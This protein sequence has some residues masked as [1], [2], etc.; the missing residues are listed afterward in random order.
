M[1]LTVVGSSDAVNAGARGN[2]CYLLESPGA[3]KL[4]I[5]FGPTA[6]LGLRRLGVAPSELGGIAFTHLHGDH[7]GG[8]PVLCIETMF[9]PPQPAPSRRPLRVLG[10]PLTQA[11]LTSLFRAAYSELEPELPA[12]VALQIDELAPGQERPF[13]GYRIRA[14]AADHMAPPHQALC[15]RITDS[16]AKTIAFSGDTRICPGL[17]AAADGADLL[18]ADCSRLTPPAGPH[19][20]WSDWQPLLPTLRARS[21][22]LTHLGADVRQSS[23]TL[24]EGLTLPLPVRFADDGMVIEI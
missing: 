9:G 1:L 20:T 17:L 4:M 21:L 19:A 14:F 13:Q 23:S 24:L 8:F 12:R 22:L 3:A 6:L 11:T 18:V 5:D 16:H 15:L 7:T 2:S 10:P